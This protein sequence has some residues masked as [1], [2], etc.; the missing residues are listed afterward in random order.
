MRVPWTYQLFGAAIL[1]C[2]LAWGLKIREE[3]RVQNLTQQVLTLQREITQ[4][5]QDQTYLQDHHETLQVLKSKG[6]EIPKS[7]LVAGEGLEELQGSNLTSEFTFHPQSTF[8]LIEGIEAYCTKIMV[9]SK[10]NTDISIYEMIERVLI[11]FPGIIFPQE[12]TLTR[13]D[14]AGEAHVKGT[15]VLDWISLKEGP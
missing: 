13:M 5:H 3:N 6:W 4:Y 12:L 15:L 9:E 7:R 8:P 2:G 11:N 10:A 14:E 1:I